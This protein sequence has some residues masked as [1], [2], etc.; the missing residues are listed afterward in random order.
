[1]KGLNTY[2][3]KSAAKLD[4]DSL[5]FSL[6]DK[7]LEIKFISGGFYDSI[8]ADTF[9]LRED[10]LPA[11]NLVPAVKIGKYANYLDSVDQNG[12]YMFLG[13]P[14]NL[15]LDRVIA[16]ELVHALMY[17]NGTRKKVCRSFL[18]KALPKLCK[19]T[20]ILTPER[21]LQLKVL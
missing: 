1:M 12:A 3:L 7:T 20:M 21:F 11:D 6:D 2:W 5:G 17:A 10:Y 18:P 13:E 14:S 8:V 9:P 19:A 16:H 15:Y 4:Y